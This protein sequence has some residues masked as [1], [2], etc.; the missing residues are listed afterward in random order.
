LLQQ[1]AAGNADPVV[2]GGDIEPVRRM[3]V[4][5]DAARFGLGTQSRGATAEGDHRSVPTLRI[6]EK[7][8]DEISF[9]IG[10]RC[11]WIPLFDMC[12]DP[13]GSHGA[14]ITDAPAATGDSG[15]Q[16]GLTLSGLRAPLR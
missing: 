16:P 3:H 9:P 1:L 7:E 2:R 4:E 11:E 15:P 6:P 5:I 8:L 14:D 12:A 13:D 10:R